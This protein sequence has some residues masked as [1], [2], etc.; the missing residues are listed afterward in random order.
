MKAKVFVAVLTIATLASAP[1]AWAENTWTVSNPSGSKFT[2]SRSG[3]TSMAETICYRTVSL[4]AFAGQ[5]FTDTSGQ[6][7]FDANEDS[8]DVTVSE[9]TPNDAYKYQDGLTR[10]Y[11]FEVTDEGGFL[12]ADCDRVITTG[13]RI[14]NTESFINTTKTA[15]IQSSDFMVTDQGFKQSGNPRTISST[16]FY[17]ATTKGYLVTAGAQL[18]MTLAFDAKEKSDGY[19]YLQILT[20]NTTGC[21]S[22]NSA[23]KGDPGKP[24]LSLYMAGFEINT[25]STDKTYRSYTFPVTS[26]GSEKGARNPW[27]HSSEGKYPLSK[28]YFNSNCRAS[29]GK[30]ILPTDFSTLVVR[31]DASGKDNDDW[32]VKNLEANI[33][34]VD[35]TAP[36]VKAYYVSNGKHCKGNTIYVSIAFSEIMTVTGTPTLS[37]NNNW[38]TLSYIGGSG[39]NVLTFSGTIGINA[40]STFGVNGIN[41]S[42]ATIKDL[43]GNSFNGPISH[44]FGT[45]LN[46]SYE[47]LI[48]YTLNDGT[49]ATD[50]PTRYTYE[51]PDFT[52]INPT[53]TGNYT[54]LGW[55]GSNGDV[56]QT[57]VTVKQGSHGALIF[58]AQWTPG[59]TVIF[60]PNG[61]IGGTKR[62]DFQIDET[63]ALAA[64]TFNRNG[65]NFSHWNT[66]ADGT[67]TS[68]NNE[69]EV[70]KLADSGKS[71][72]LYAQW[73][74]DYSLWNQD[75][76]HDGTT[77]DKSYII[78]SAQG[79]GLLAELVKGGNTYGPDNTH[80]N[81]YFFKLGSNITYTPS[82]AWDKESNTENNFTVIGDKNNYFCGTFDGDNHTISGIRLY[83]TM[84]YIGLF[85][86]IGNEGTVKNLTLSNTRI[87]VKRSQCIGGIAG[88]NQGIIQ[89]C[90]L[91]DD[92]CIICDGSDVGGITGFN[93]NNSDTYATIRDCTSSV[94]MKW[95]GTNKGGIAGTN[96]G[97]IMNCFAESVKILNSPNNAGAIAGYSNNA[98]YSD[99]YYYNCSVKNQTT[100][101]GLSDKNGNF[102]NAEGVWG[103]SKI[104]LG[105][106]IT[107]SAK[108]ITYNNETY[109]YSDGSVTLS[110]GNGE[111]EVAFVVKKASDNSEI[112]RTSSR[113]ELPGYD[114]T[115]STVAAL[116]QG[117]G[118]EQSP[119]IINDSHDM[120]Q[121]IIKINGYDGV[122]QN[123]YEGKYFRLNA[124]ITFSGGAAQSNLNDDGTTSRDF[125]GIFDGN[126]KYISGITVCPTGDTDHSI[127]G[128]LN[129]G[130]IK[131][132]TIKNSTIQAT[133]SDNTVTSVENYA[134][135]CRNQKSGTIQR[136]TVMDCTINVQN[137]LTLTNVGAICANLNG[138]AI[139]G[140]NV[141]CTVQNLRVANISGGINRPILNTF[142]G[143]C[144]KVTGGTISN[145][146]TEYSSL[147]PSASEM[148]TLYIG[149][150]VGQAAPLSTLN[151]QLSTVIEDCS[152][153]QS[154]VNSYRYSGGIV[155]KVDHPNCKILRC[156]STCNSDGYYYARCNDSYAG[157]IA[158]W[159]N[160]DA[161]HPD[162]SSI[163]D[164][165][166][167]VDVIADFYV[168]GIASHASNCRVSGCYNKHDICNYYT[169]LGGIV[170]ELTGKSTIQECFNVGYVRQYDDE[171]PT[172]YMGGI[173]GYINAT[174]TGDECKVQDCFNSNM[175]YGSNCIGGIAGMMEGNACLT[176]CY[177]TGVVK[178]VAQVGGLIGIKKNGTL[179]TTDCYTAG[180]V[181]GSSM[182]GAAC[183]YVTS[184]DATFSNCYYDNQMVAYKGVDDNRDVTGIAST[185]HANMIGTGLQSA[186]G[187][188]KWTYSD[189]HFP[190]LTTLSSDGTSQF[191]KVS[192]LIFSLTAD[193]N[194]TNLKR[195]TQ[196]EMDGDQIHLPSEDNIIWSCDDPSENQY[197][198][199]ENNDNNTYSLYSEQRKIYNICIAN[200][201]NISESPMRVFEINVGIS[202]EQPLVIEDN[203][204]FR[205]FRNCINSGQYFTF[206][207]NSSSNSI[208]DLSYSDDIN[209]VHIPSNAEGYYFKLTKDLWMVQDPD[210]R[211][212]RWDP[213][214][215]YSTNNK[216]S[217]RGS[218]DGDGHKI[219]FKSNRPEDNSIGLF[220]SMEG[221]IKNL[222]VTASLQI[223]ADFVNGKDYVGALAGFCQGT[224]ENCSVVKSDSTQF[225]PTVSGNNYVGALVGKAEYSKIINCHNEYCY[226]SGNENVGNVIGSTD[227]NTV[228]S[229]TISNTTPVQTQLALM[230]FD[231][232]QPETKKNTV[233]LSDFYNN[234][235]IPDH[236]A[237]VFVLP[238]RVLYKDGAWN[239][240][241]LPFSLSAEQIAASQLAG[242]TIMEL[243]TQG[244]Y[245]GHKTGVDVTTG[246]LYLY[247]KNATSI[248]AGKPYLIK[249]TRASD[250]APYDYTTHITHDIHNP[251][252]YDVQID[253]S[254]AAIDRQ[255]VISSDG[256]VYFVGIYSGIQYL[257]SYPNLKTIYLLSA[258]NKLRHPDAPKNMG[259]CRAYFRLNGL[260][261]EVK[262]CILNFWED[263]DAD[264]FKDIRDSKDLND[265]AIYDLSGRKIANGQQSTAKG[266]YIVNG[267]KILKF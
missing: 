71:I 118:T 136:V 225:V 39:T 90:H 209:D 32:Y 155:G 51:T 183:G 80:P 221:R 242:T 60:Y 249:W 17:N 103:I 147:N 259:G 152:F 96:K 81:G 263:D 163:E 177:N 161:E 115:I 196:D 176:R 258:D 207:L 151:S 95:G 4:T 211:S 110:Y 243:D 75:A 7:T 57:E 148:T 252:F 139:G 191:S 205:D 132:L 2:I 215:Y 219:Y 59:Y 125:K 182:I 142:G 187:T 62:Q 54:F 78:T 8:K 167:N 6:L 104:T 206:H 67:G 30:L 68:Y 193:Q 117:D 101:V 112:L 100:N 200:N 189:N 42:G 213:I 50:K 267:K 45:S 140:A 195:N 56:P 65:F 48:N 185:A 222:N 186:L 23:D 27:G 235:N 3:D 97:E 41:L 111:D 31:F 234:N 121:L 145:C 227:D 12:L 180:K 70:S 131:D 264:G 21:D 165:Y 238:D 79:L 170:G 164:C 74:P 126:D 123:A 166:N 22:E 171:Y 174:Q 89:N 190:Q 173:V 85:S 120:K 261:T 92:V 102:Y 109:Y 233:L 40:S 262:E 244:T 15:T 220:G 29:N 18:Q 230:N 231:F 130:T 43:N 93:Y 192:T 168:G 134:F 122:K 73:T 114:I 72:S 5:H 179:T 137:Q 224:L 13:S 245:N 52:L 229:D 84:S 212:I 149:G 232:Y 53:R 69:A 46:D 34:A 1:S 105:T 138:G 157:G 128:D 223:E 63:K 11:R 127:F 198:I 99:T 144:G 254:Q 129:G 208:I 86:L 49:I 181:E 197:I 146:K 44:N 204:T 239:T 87:W 24:T 203:T 194:T 217:F 37:T 28:Q 55:T 61:G 216:H 154:T 256:R 16:S 172:I 153:V 202:A 226:V 260:N 38:G 47:Y 218:L 20:D 257:S 175:I 158:G 240:L 119:F 199:H 178:G 116:W 250:Y 160:G 251:E 91:T 184:A 14:T 10:E 210:S 94:T 33:T 26:V 141:G 98:I 83:Q 106:G 108:S 19:Q 169:H 265:G 76:D 25:G 88:Y 237:D 143:I 241:C 236:K 201:E 82:S 253:N 255:T 77:A 162:Q 64:N 124:D 66:R 36:T 188:D 247:F 159:F 35:N 214:G 133:T 246:T 248:Q 58:N 150:I 9:L 156:S 228:V 135:L 113:F 107:T 266:L